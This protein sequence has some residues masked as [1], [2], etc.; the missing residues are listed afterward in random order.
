[1]RDHRN[2]WN[3]RD[4]SAGCKLRMWSFY[5]G[6]IDMKPANVFIVVLR[7]PDRSDPNEKR[8]D[9]FWE[10]GSFGSTT[11]H[12]KNLLNP[13]Q[14]KTRL[15]GARLGFA[16]GGPESFRLVMLTPM[17]KVNDFKAP[18]EALWNPK[19]M[20]FRYARAPLLVDAEGRSDFGFIRR[21]VRRGNCLSPTGQ[22]SSSFRTRSTPLKPA[23]GNALIRIYDS[24]VKRA[25]RQAF[26]ETYLDAL[27]WAPPV[28]ESPRERRRSYRSF[29][30]ERDLMSWPRAKTRKPGG[31]DASNEYPRQR[32]VRKRQR[33]CA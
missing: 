32:C 28:T 5:G 6:S 21:L 27:P 4:S 9:P 22:F 1:V 29:L 25:S 30:A 15:E 16:Q 18:S 20:P 11:C 31:V 2:S 10:F 8:E 7:R 12:M 19:R 3:R 23:D 14:A 17:V 24:K 33:Q 26:A 13:K